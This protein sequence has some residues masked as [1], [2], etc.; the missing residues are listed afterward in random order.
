MIA[1]AVW[2]GLVGVGYVA[3]ERLSAPQA[4][5]ID[6]RQ[7]RDG[8]EDRSVLHHKRRYHLR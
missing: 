4:E 6:C 8:A 2:L 5:L 1:A 3:F 7:G